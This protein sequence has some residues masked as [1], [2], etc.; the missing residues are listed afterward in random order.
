MREKASFDRL[1]VTLFSL[2]ALL[3]VLAFLGMQATHRSQARAARPVAL[4]RR[5][6]VTTV[7]ERVPA[8]STAHGGSVTQSVSSSGALS[9]AAPITR[10]S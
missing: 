4:L 5:V 10:T 1:T 7:V 2:A 3:L 9:G 6:Y 8:H